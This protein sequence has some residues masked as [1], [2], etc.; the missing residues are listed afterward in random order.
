MAKKQELPG[1]RRK[2]EI[3]FGKKTSKEKLRETAEQFLEAGRYYDALEFIERADAPALARKIVRLAMDAGDT[4]LLMR[5][6]K[7]LREDVTE[8]EWSRVAA[9]AEKAGLYSAA[10]LAH[11]KAGHEEQAAR[12][13]KAMPGVDE[14]ESQEADEPDGKTI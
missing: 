8:E 5:A 7:V 2:R 3:L 12:L 14:E 10:W 13:R 6:K 11:S 4:P 9:N 1:F